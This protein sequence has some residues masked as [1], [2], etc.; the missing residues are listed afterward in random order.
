MSEKADAALIRQLTKEVDEMQSLERGCHTE[1]T[2]S[3]GKWR[4]ILQLARAGA[5]PPVPRS[6]AAEPG[7]RVEPPARY[8]R[9][10]VI[11]GPG[12]STEEGTPPPFSGIPYDQPTCTDASAG[13]YGPW[14]DGESRCGRAARKDGAR[15]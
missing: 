10:R 13:F 3:V 15:G 14:Q 2:L 4:R 9:T 6:T 12:R 11:G 1:V 7:V 8:D 5:R